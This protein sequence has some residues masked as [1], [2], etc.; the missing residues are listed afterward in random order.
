M[1]SDEPVPHADSVLAA[2][3]KHLEVKLSFGETQTR[4]ITT[5]QKNGSY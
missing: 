5:N 2:L 4:S 3:A 1:L